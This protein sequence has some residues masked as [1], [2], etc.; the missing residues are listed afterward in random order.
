MGRVERT[1]T[2]QEGVSVCV[3]YYIPVQFYGAG[4]ILLL[5]PDSFCISKRIEDMNQ[6]ISVSIVSH[7]IHLVDFYG[8]CG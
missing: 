6:E 4:K 8:K 3:L 7:W 2:W 1:T 5:I